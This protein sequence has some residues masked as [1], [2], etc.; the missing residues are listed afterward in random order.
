MQQKCIHHLPY[1]MNATLFHISTWQTL[2]VSIQESNFPLRALLLVNTNGKNSQQYSAFSAIL[3]D[4]IHVLKTE[5]LTAEE[6]NSWCQ[7]H[8]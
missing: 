3:P 4:Y 5:A 2:L 6:M 7:I 8:N 1:S